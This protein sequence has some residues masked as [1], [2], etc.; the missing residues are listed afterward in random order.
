MPK[1]S[2]DPITRIEGH[3][4]VE[5]DI[6]REP[7][8]RNEYV[9]REARSKATMFRGFEL[10]LKDRDPRD[11]VLI[12]QR[13]CGVCP[14]PHAMA[15]VQALEDA[16]HVEPPAA[17]ILVRNILEAAYITYDHLIHFYLL[18]GPELGI[19]C[20]HPPMV[21][22][23]LGIDGIKTL[24]LGAH[25]A[26]CIEVQRAASRTVALWGGKFP[27]IQSLYPGGVTVRPTLDKIASSVA[28][29]VSV[30]E[31]I[32]TT[33]MADFQAILAANERLKAVTEATLGVRVGL[34]NMGASTGNFLCYGLFPDHADYQDWLDPAKRRKS[35][36]RS[37]TWSADGLAAFDES[38]IRE[39]VRY[40]FYDSPSGLHPSEGETSPKRDKEGAYSW[41]KAP[42]YG[43]EV[44]EVGPLAR[45]M[46]TFG[47]NWRVERVHPTTGEDYGPVE[48]VLRNPRGSV[49]DR[50][51]AR[52]FMLMLCAN[53][54]F[55]WLLELRDYMGEPIV[56][57][58]TIP[59]EAKGRGL[60][61][62]PRGA[63]GHWI[64]I[65][66]G[67]IARYQCVVPGTWNWSPRDDLGNPGPG[68]QA[69]QCGTT[70]I[71]TLTVPQLA[72][73]IQAGWGDTLARALTALNPAYARLNMETT[74]TPESVNSSI[75]LLIV[76]SFDPCLACG[77]HMIMP[78]GK[79]HSIELDDHH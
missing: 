4:G 57:S 24:G 66:G 26:K 47:T 53:K 27:H 22:P 64:T 34:E 46:T 59:N 43:E 71:P 36:I 58:M 54:A 72:N 62:A 51:A 77:V 28:R 19:L 65:K 20:A 18:I 45:M 6:A 68:E 17:A 70:W 13:I 5:L 75:P 78:D 37:G 9:V 35:V 25:Y 21:P 29:M 23:A 76:R 12:T 63:L 38:K 40:S 44:F 8:L 56:N 48:Y 32:A 30:W 31:F 79:R 11:A 50:F 60:W 33:A 16:F 14:N 61:E 42:R 69:L 10:L 7:A 41:T 55:E 15:S 49:L 67:R 74:D 52:A 2:I 39:Y 3:M 1:F 73:L